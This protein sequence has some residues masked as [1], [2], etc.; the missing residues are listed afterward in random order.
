MSVRDMKKLTQQK[1]VN[2]P[3]VQEKK[4]KSK[5]EKEKQTNRLMSSYFSGVSDKLTSRA[6]NIYFLSDSLI[7]NILHFQKLRKGEL[8]GQVNV[9]LNKSV[10][11]K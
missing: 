3:E 10:I 2:L 11:R 5:V 1:F 8:K 6:S 9:D 7:H 4:L